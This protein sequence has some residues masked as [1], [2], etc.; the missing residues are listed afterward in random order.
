[1]AQARYAASAKSGRALFLKAVKEELEE[2]N[3]EVEFPTEYVSGNVTFKVA[4][5][6]PPRLACRTT[7]AALTRR[8]TWAG[9]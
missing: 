5:V 8:L 3:N 7:P 2:E 1:M 4:K 6:A 9:G